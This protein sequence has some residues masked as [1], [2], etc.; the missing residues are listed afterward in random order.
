MTIIKRVLKT[1][2]A[3]K[4]KTTVSLRSIKRS[5]NS[6]LLE[7]P[8]KLEGQVTT[9]ALSREVPFAANFLRVVLPSL[10]QQLRPTRLK[11]D[12]R[13]NPAIMKKATEENISLKTKLL[14]PKQ[15]PLL[16]RATTMTSMKQLRLLTNR[17]SRASKTKWPRTLT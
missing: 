2:T 16:T 14:M 1:L 12:T 4:R 11:V 15:H 7:L 10:L 3:K 8:K 5:Q 6:N 9:T 13:A 17:S